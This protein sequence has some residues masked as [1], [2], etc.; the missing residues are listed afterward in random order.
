MNRISVSPLNKNFSSSVILVKNTTKKILSLL[1]KDNCCIEIFLVSNLAIKKINRVWRK[2]NKVTNVLSFCEP[3]NFIHSPSKFNFLGEIY[4]CLDYVRS[5]SQSIEH[6]L[7]HGILHL[8]GY[9]HETIKDQKNM[10]RIEDRILKKI[11]SK[12]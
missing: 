5:H 8:L 6:M 2:K 1:K 7:V 10:E 12:F 3:K 11:F 9:D 4:I